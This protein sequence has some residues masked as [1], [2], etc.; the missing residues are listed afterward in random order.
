MSNPEYHHYTRVTLHLSADGPRP[1]KIDRDFDEWDDAVKFAQ[2]IAVNAYAA[3]SDGD[4]RF[5]PAHRI[6]EVTCKKS[7]IRK[8]ESVQA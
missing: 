2:S 5:I 6:Q 8:M 3:G 4:M 7:R 1:L